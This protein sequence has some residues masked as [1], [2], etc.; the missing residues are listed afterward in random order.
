MIIEKLQEIK[1]E[2]NRL[3][4]LYS[5]RK[6]QEQEQEEQLI[7]KFQPILETHSKHIKNV[8]LET[9]RA[10]KDPWI[11]QG[12]KDFYYRKFDRGLFIPFN[13]NDEELKLI[14]E[15]P[16]SFLN[17]LNEFVFSLP[18]YAIEFFSEEKTYFI[19]VCFI[20]NITYIQPG[21]AELLNEYNQ[22]R[23]RTK[24]HR[25]KFIKD[26]LLKT[27]EHSRKE[28]ERVYSI[29]VEYIN[30]PQIIQ[31][32]K[33]DGLSFGVNLLKSYFVDPSRVYSLLTTKTTI[34]LKNLVFVQ[35]NHSH[36]ISFCFLDI[37]SNFPFK[38]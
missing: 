10:D 11:F 33:K 19:N 7:K 17:K 8:L 14:Q 36:D 38:G 15:N 2:S 20:N 3:A 9:F 13:F 6:K 16:E 32:L 35:K 28:A 4:E 29:F 34:D 23:E 12:Q 22:M 30:D 24:K 25:K 1:A 21:C 26:V 5:A 27:D 37:A 31:K 18:T